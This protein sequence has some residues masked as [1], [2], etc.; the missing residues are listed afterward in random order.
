MIIRA[1]LVDWIILELDATE[2]CCYVHAKKTRS[3]YVKSEILASF[4]DVNPR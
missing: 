2:Q 1:V 4:C 3:K